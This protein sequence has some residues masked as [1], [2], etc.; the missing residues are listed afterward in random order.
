MAAESITAANVLPSTSAVITYGTAGATI[1]QGQLVYIDT[2]DSNKIKLADS[3]ASSTASTVA[4]LALVAAS[5]G[6]RVYYITSDPSLTLG[7]TLAAGDTLWASPTAGGITKTEADLVAG[8]YKTTV[9]IMTSTT[10]CNFKINRGGLK[11]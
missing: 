9:G 3:D 11:V 5:S 6:Q 7:A 1:T 10:L 4:W 2:G 8:N